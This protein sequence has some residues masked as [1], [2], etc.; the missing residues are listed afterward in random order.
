V[1]ERFNSAAAPTSVLVCRVNCVGDRDICTRMGIRS[2]PTLR[3]G[4]PDDF[5]QADATG[6]WE[7]YTVNVEANPRTAAGVSAWVGQ[8]LAQQFVL[9]DEVA[10]DASL[11]QMMAAVTTGGQAVDVTAGAA[12][13]QAWDVELAMVMAREKQIG[14]S[15]GSLEPPGPLS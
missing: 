5:M 3:W 12:G 8:E 13:L 14:G 6:D 9:T 2:F 10:F 11:A 15:G 1:G 4:A 7:Q